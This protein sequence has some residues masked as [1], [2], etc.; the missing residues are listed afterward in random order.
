MNDKHTP[1]PWRASIGNG[2]NSNT[3]VMRGEDEIC[4]VFDDC[5][6][7]ALP[8]LANA[9]LI[10]AAPDMLA[11]LVQLEEYLRSTPHHNAV[12]AAH[13]RRVIKKATEGR[14]S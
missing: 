4:E 12:E 14:V 3:Y 9:R 1:G 8:D 2:Y 10:A 6:S 13:A 5:D 7:E 11:A